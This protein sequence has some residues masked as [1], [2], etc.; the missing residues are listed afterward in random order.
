MGQSLGS[1]VISGPAPG[2]CADATAGPSVTSTPNIKMTASQDVDLSDNRQVI[3]DL[4]SREWDFGDPMP[5]G[6]GVVES[7]TPAKSS[8]YELIS[9]SILISLNSGASQI[10]GL[11]SSLGSSGKK[12][13]RPRLLSCHRTGGCRRNILKRPSAVRGPPR[14]VERI[15]RRTNRPSAAGV[16]TVWS[17]GAVARAGRATRRQPPTVG[18]G[19][20]V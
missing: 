10:I 1:G 13:A 11:T 4:T 17:P 15:R 9:A 8:W 12:D 3:V 2:A 6:T 14:C 16:V 5:S 18:N 20:A 7:Q 19:S